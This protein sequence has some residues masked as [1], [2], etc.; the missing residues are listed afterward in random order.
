[1]GHKKAGSDRLV[2]VVTGDVV[3]S[4]ELPANVRSQLP[5]ILRSR[6]RDAVE[7]IPSAMVDG[8]ALVSGD[9]WQVLFH[10]PGHALAY[11]LGFVARLRSEA[12]ETRAALALGTI[13]RLA[14]DLNASD[15]PAFRQ[16]GRGL[17]TMRGD[18]RL[19]M[20]APAEGQ[21]AAGIATAALAELADH[22]LQ[23]WTPAQAQAV[24][25]MLDGWDDQTVH[26]QAEVGAAWTPE[27]VTRQTVNRHLQRA[28]FDRVE[29]TLQRYAALVQSLSSSN[30][31]PSP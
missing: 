14:E 3:H 11:T 21:P 22:L 30:S 4:T 16:S 31:N 9:G 23:A 6:F 27:P 2:V 7:G 8:L 20:L 12:I 5:E 25:G 18:Q 26:T 28:A 19:N 17:R 1:M 13:D 24:A 15:G 10:E 29:R